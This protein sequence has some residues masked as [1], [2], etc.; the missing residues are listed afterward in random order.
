MSW[1]LPEGVTNQDIEDN[2][3]CPS[4]EEWEEIERYERIMEELED[5][6]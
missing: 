3:G 5:D 1:N 6:E 2:F 4:V